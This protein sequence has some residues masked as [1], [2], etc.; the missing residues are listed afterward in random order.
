MKPAPED[1]RRAEREVLVRSEIIAPGSVTDPRVIT[2]MR[3][4]PR[5]EFVPSYETDEAYADHPLPIGH[6]Q[7]ISQP[8]LVAWMTQAL[9][10]KSTDRILE[11]GSG[12]GYQAAVLSRLAAEIYS[13]EIIPELAEMARNNLA[14]VGV[15][16]VHVR[17]GDGY[18]GWPEAAPFDGVIV[19]CCP[20][21]VPPPLIEQLRDGGRVV[22]PVERAFG[23]NLLVLQRD[24]DRLRE[25]RT[26]PVRFVPMTGQ[27]E[28]D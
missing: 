6:G 18:F 3:E 25:L 8:S 10:P 16:N 14:R 22:I 4:V 21:K 12:S 20:S 5:H 19:T 27:A 17:A 2:A 11:I 13:I 9:E 24:G 1:P 7:T 28:S 26:L 15:T 23:Q